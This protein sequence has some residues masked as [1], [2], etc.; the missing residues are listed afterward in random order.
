M[1]ERNKAQGYIQ[2]VQSSTHIIHDIHQD[3]KGGAEVQLAK[4]CLFD[5]P[6]SL[7][8]TFFVEAEVSCLYE[9][10]YWTKLLNF[11]LPSFGLGTA[12]SLILTFVPRPGCSTFLNRE[13]PVYVIESAVNFMDL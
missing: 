11:V 10:P 2:A 9:G 13:V 8:E 3:K 5:L 12:N 4:K 1:V 7:S 6:A